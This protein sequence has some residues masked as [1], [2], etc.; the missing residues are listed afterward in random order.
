MWRAPQLLARA[1]R[2][3]DAGDVWLEPGRSGRSAMTQ[4]QLAPPHLDVANLPGLS[5][6]RKRSAGKKTGG[7]GKWGRLGFRMR[8][9][10]RRHGEGRFGAMEGRGK[11][12]RRRSLAC[13]RRGCLGLFNW[14]ERGDL[15]SRA[16]Q[17]L[18]SRARQNFRTRTE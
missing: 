13:R 17:E 6:R 5:R 9:R 8:T 11:Q 10:R 4:S 7:W 16:R 1:T 18:E 2:S 15:A 14:L 12:G 3:V